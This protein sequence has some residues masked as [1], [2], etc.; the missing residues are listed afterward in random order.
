M[1]ARLA[2]ALLMLAGA[3]PALAQPVV[4]SQAIDDV[5]VSVYRD[6]D[7]GEDDMSIGYLQGFALISEKR[8]IDLPQGA[9]TVRFDGVAEGMVAVSAIVTGLPGGTVQKNRD[10]AI[11]S[12][13]ALVDGTLGNRVTLKRTN[14]ATGAVREV[15]AIVRTVAWRGLVLQTAEGYEALRCSGLPEGLVFGQ[16]PPGLSARPVLSV[17]TYSPEAVRVQVTLTYLATGFDWSANYVATMADDGDT[18]D[19]TAWLT[20]ANDNGQSFADANLNAIAGTLNIESDF[21]SLAEAPDGNPLYLECYPLGSTADGSD[22]YDLLPPPSPPPAPM[23]MAGAMNENIIVTAARRQEK[24]ADS[25]V[26]TAGQEE[27][28]DLKLYRVPFRSTVAANGQKQV[29]FAVKRGVKVEKIYR[30][31]AWPWDEDENEPLDIEL[32]MKNRD[33]DGLGLPL[34]SGGIAL[35]EP[36]AGE[37]LLVGEAEMRDYPVNADVK[38]IIAS[39]PQV[40]MT[41]ENVGDEKSG[42]QGY[43]V[44]LTNA[45]DFAVDAE[46][47]L[48]ATGEWKIRRAKGRIIAKNGMHVWVVRVPA[49]GSADLS[50]QLSEIYD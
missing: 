16:V 44:N 43:R 18:M 5:S 32:R 14:P 33:S 35:F 50:Y 30:A 9:S 34:P 41:N 4:S 10:A 19:I 13:A 48:G 28:G 26:V 17:E 31:T 21:D 49:N 24:F 11:L 27:L 36:A 23:M 45:N 12:P 40:L 39:S 42:W 25:E 7:R 3:L 20:L 1:I 47:G 6:P 37:E 46:I 8:T 38:F 29:A 15:D 22:V 2:L